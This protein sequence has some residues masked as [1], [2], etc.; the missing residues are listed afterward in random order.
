[1]DYLKIYNSIVERGKDRVITGYT[2]THHIIP[3]CLGG[4]NDYW[5]LVVLTAKEHFICH[6]LLCEIY[7]KNIKLRFALWNMCNVKRKYQD[8]YKINSRL[9]NLIRKEY[10]KS[11]TGVN[12]PS[13]GRSLTEEQKA[14][15]SL[16]R[17]GKYGGEKNSFYG[18]KHT[19]ETR[20]IL[21]KKNFGKKHS[22]DA[23]K[24]MSESHKNKL[25]YFND[26]GKHLRTFLDDP[27]I[28]EEGWKKGRMGGKELSKLANEKRKEKYSTT[29]PSK[30]NSKKCLIDGLLFDSAVNA[31][32]HFNMPNSS[33][34]DRIRNKNFPT[35]NWV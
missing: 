25:W 35:W 4:S 19:D 2:E 24:K 12:N 10:S 31:A 29:E 15:I 3:K 21:R 16:S 22:D 30:P 27:R 7:P 33:V 5:N 28:V 9:Y 34:R 1:M 6:L 26:E 32:K 8:R 20:E 11:V 17:I 13:F 23:K 14:K 18:K